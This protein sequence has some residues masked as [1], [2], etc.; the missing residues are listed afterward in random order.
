MPTYAA[1]AN[2][3]RYIFAGLKDLLA[4]ASAEK[5]GDQL[6]GIAARNQAHRVA[7]RYALADLPLREFLDHALIP[8]ETDE[9]TRLIIDGHDEQA[10]APVS[11]LSVGGFRDWLLSDGVDADALA[12]VAPGITPEMAAAVSKVMRNQDLMAVSRK[13]EVITGFRTTMGQRGTL[14]SRLQPNHPVDDLSGILAATVDGL[15]LGCGDAVIGVNPAT[16]SVAIGADIL[17]MLDDL[18][19]AYDIPVQT[20]VL[21]H[22]TTGIELVRIGAPVDLIFQSIGGT[23]DTNSGFGVDLN[24]LF[25]AHDAAKGLSRGTVGNNVM[26][27][28]TGQGSS[29]SSGSHHHVDQQTLEARAYGLARRLDPLLV[30]NV[31]GF[32]GPEYIDGAPQLVRAGLEDHFCG[33]LLGIPMGTDVCYTNHAAID[34]NDCEVLATLLVA[35]GV[36]FVI[37]VAGGDDVMLGYQSL[38]F[39]DVLYLQRL[40]GVGPAPEFAAWL[41]RAGLAEAGQDRL[42]SG[43]GDHMLQRIAGR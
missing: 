19:Q 8:Y 14:S 7:A 32:I 31:V 1:V 35:A 41:A 21:S 5:T 2:G 6:A 10:F 27:L 26:Y 17:R 30:N 28:E 24:L 43:M 4:A 36:N 15:L 22:I 16:D 40:F 25:E 3:Q 12:A 18:R 20:C 13:C 34:Q 29:L 38:S 9:V 39:H 33:K 37:A 42:P 23:Q 11:S